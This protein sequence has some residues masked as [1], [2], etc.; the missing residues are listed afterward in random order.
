[1]PIKE[2]LIIFIN[3]E[4]LLFFFDTKKIKFFEQ[5]IFFYEKYFL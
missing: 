2:G 3:G 5:I 4:S 1:M